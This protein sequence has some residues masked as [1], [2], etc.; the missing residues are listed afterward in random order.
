MAL[1][2]AAGGPLAM[3]V[4]PRLA[5]EPA[6]LTIQT[7]IEANSDNGLRLSRSRC[8]QTVMTQRPGGTIAV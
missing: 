2:S 5:L 6:L 3:R 8:V 4:S 7:T 1:P